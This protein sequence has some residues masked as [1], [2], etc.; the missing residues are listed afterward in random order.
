MDLRA[1]VAETL[2]NLRSQSA[3]SAH[4]QKA[5]MQVLE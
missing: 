5:K 3:A 4:K 1:T 2:R